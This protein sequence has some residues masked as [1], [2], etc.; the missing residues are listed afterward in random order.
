MNDLKTAEDIRKRIAALEAQ[1]SNMEIELKRKFSATVDSLSPGNLLK[2]TLSGLN[3]TPG[4]KYALFSTILNLGLSF[5]GGRML[6]S[7]GGIAKKAA[8]AAL[9]L[10]V[11]KLLSKNISV[12]KRFAVNLFTKDKKVA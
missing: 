1:T 6:F 8:G 11:S 9:E 7:K 2:N 5:A 3:E 10:G 12:L 4:L